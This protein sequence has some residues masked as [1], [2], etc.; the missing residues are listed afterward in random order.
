MFE[1][2]KKLDRTDVD[3]FTAVLVG[4]LQFQ[5]RSELV[6]VSTG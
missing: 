5:D 6:S 2:G 3:R 4:Y 1:D